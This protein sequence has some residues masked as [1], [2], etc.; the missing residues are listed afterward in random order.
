MNTSD[1]RLDDLLLDGAR[2]WRD[3]L[4]SHQDRYHRFIP[5]DQRDAFVALRDLRNRAHSFLEL[6]SGTGV[7]TI[8]ADLLG[9][10]ACGIE[11][12]AE[13]VT[14]SRDLCESYESH[15]TFV[16]GSFVP[17]EYRD[18]ISLLDADFLT[19]TEGADAYE[20][21]GRDIA[22]FDVVYAYPWPGEEDWME[23]LVRRQ[24]GTHTSLLT[25]SVREGFQTVEFD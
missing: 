20:E 17:V 15:A 21:L 10:D 9:F 18:E 12:D 14:T 19:V 22:D 7:I 23:E 16:E 4:A 6:G 8:M 1:A 2:A 13:L 11:I 25:Y 24:A 3:F 5:A